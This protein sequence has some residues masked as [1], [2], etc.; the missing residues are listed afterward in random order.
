MS[1]VLTSGNMFMLDGSS[2]PGGVE[3]IPML[4][5]GR[6]VGVL[7]RGDVFVLLEAT[8]FEDRRGSRINIYTT[9]WQILAKGQE[10]TIFINRD[11]RDSLRLVASD[12]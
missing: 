4:R 3:R 12:K 11:E 5:N 8:T 2:R 10:A 9:H 6:Q 7:E 1:G